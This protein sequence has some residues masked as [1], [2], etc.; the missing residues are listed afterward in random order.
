M[1]VS[2]SCC[3]TK[4]RRVVGSLLAAAGERGGAAKC[5]RFEGK[6][7]A[8]VDSTRT[9]HEALTECHS[10]T[11]VALDCFALLSRY[12]A[13]SLHP[14]A[15][16]QHAACRCSNPPRDAP[17]PLFRLGESPR[18]EQ[19][20]S[21]RNAAAMLANANRPSH[22]E[23]L[24]SGVDRYNPSS[25]FSSPTRLDPPHPHDTRS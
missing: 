9:L 4:D 6:P 16:V 1:N 8:A 21:S 10:V 5:G 18:T 3:L 12:G 23:T 20:P 7:V 17:P 11:G 24:I 22:I 14:L 2:W 25:E 13:R 19:K 15:S